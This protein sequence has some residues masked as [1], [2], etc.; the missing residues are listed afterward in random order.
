MYKYVKNPF[1][2]HV[3]FMKSYDWNSIELHHTTP[4]VLLSQHIP[5]TCTKVF[6][7][8][9]PFSELETLQQQAC[10]TLNKCT[11]TKRS[12]KDRKI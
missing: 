12:L 3:C 6:I 10:N 4:L 11:E 5:V 9:T 2:T 8:S 7:D 1:H